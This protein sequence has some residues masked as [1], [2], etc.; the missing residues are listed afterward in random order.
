[1][2][3][4]LLGTCIDMGLSYHMIFLSH[5][6]KPLNCFPKLVSHFAFPPARYAGSNFLISALTLAIICLLDLSHSRGSD[7]WAITLNILSCEDKNICFLFMR[8][9]ST[10]YQHRTIY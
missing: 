3:S 6:Q 7:W 2:F 5:I 10:W 9:L 4:I 1:M 8:H